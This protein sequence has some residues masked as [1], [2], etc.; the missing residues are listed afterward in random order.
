MSDGRTL[1]VILTANASAYKAALSGAGRDTEEFGRKVDRAGH[2]LDAMGA[3][4]DRSAAQIAGF[5]KNTRDAGNEVDRMSGRLR[6]MLDALTLLGPAMVPIGAVAIPALTGLAAQL[7][8]AG[9]AA[10]STML[11]FIGMGDALTALNA[12]QLNP[13]AA[14]IEKARVALDKLG[15]S[16]AAFTLELDRM[17]PSL[18]T[19][20]QA[21]A[22]GFFPG[23]LD[24]LQSVEHALPTI[25]RLVNELAQSA[26][27]MAASLGD[28]LDSRRF[29]KFSRFVESEARPTM[30]T[31]FDTVSNL[32]NGLGEMWM[33]FDPINDDFGQWLL[34]QSRDFD[35]WAAKLDKTQGFEDFMAYIREEGPRVADALGSIGDMT[36]QIV[37]AA[38]PIGGPVLEGISAMADAVSA[39]A[40]SPIG[41]TLFGAAAA[42]TVLNRGLQMT[43]ALLTKVGIAG[44][45]AGAGAAAGTMRGNIA[46]IKGGLSPSRFTPAAWTASREASAATR[47]LAAAEATARTA[48]AEYVGALKASS[49]QQELIPGAK[50]TQGMTGAVDKLNAANEA[51]VTAANRV[52]EAEERRAAAIRNTARQAAGGAAA[53]AAIG[54]LSTDAGQGLGLTNTAMLGLVGSM[55]GPWG[56]AMGAGVGA[57]I[58]FRSET[59]RAADAWRSFDSV[60][61][62]ASSFT[63]AEG[64]FSRF[65]EQARPTAGGSILSGTLN[66]LTLGAVGQNVPDQINAY[67][68]AADA[69]ESK[70]EDLRLGAHLLGEQFN[71]MGTSTADLDRA[72]QS[73]NPAMSALG[74]STDDLIAAV[75]DGSIIQLV[76]DITEWQQHADSA[77]GQTDAVA[78][79]VKNLGYDALSTADS[80]QQLGTALQNALTPN[81]D[82]EAATDAWHTALTKL[83][84]D[85]K[86][87]KGF[88][89]FGEGAMANRQLTRDYAS[90]SIDRLTKLAGVN[91]TTPEAM[92]KA[93]EATRR[94]FIK[95]GVA[96]GFSAEQMKRRAN[97]LKLTPKLVRTVFHAAGIT[98]VDLRAREL[99]AVYKGMPKDVRTFIQTHGVPQTKAEI[100]DLVKKYHLTEKQRTALVTLK[101]LASK[102]IGDVL[103]RLGI[104]DRTSAHPKVQAEA[105]AAQRALDRAAASLAALDGRVAKSIVEIHT[106]RTGAGGQGRGY[107]G[108]AGGGTVPVTGLG[109]ADRHPY[110]LADGEE[111][112]TDSPSRGRPASTYRPVLKAINRG[113][114]RDVIRGMLAGGGTAGRYGSTL[115][116]GGRPVVVVRDRLPDKLDLVVD[117]QRMTAFVRGHAEQVVHQR[118]IEQDDADTLTERMNWR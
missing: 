102:N 81:I 111:V 118:T 11:A 52:R 13:T 2:D 80:A 67:G 68:D 48:H 60:I 43:A 83:R 28:A 27:D 59:D 25:R 89:G 96:A 113:A 75:Q 31:L 33:A 3:S 66:N 4:S 61:G 99:T 41:T 108:A 65:K 69:A 85:L 44:E 6:I 109:Y 30:A 77:A 26:G 104:L 38:A 55:A 15:P 105:A 12:A 40:D 16:A 47:D 34:D 29:A 97:E 84:T 116:G 19:V 115:A 35:A 112:V 39:I 86:P 90:T 54:V 78:E 5:E 71:I 73:A 100:D 9:G 74:L 107:D 114:S 56:A 62:S 7:A 50:A 49:V 101:D 53:I 17:M 98:Q 21:S 22:S 91:T 95:E 76:Q 57:L 92:A 37:E 1:Y 70:V 87:G 36:L 45:V 24:G 82:L 10:G 42:A 20:Q 58:D 14:N 51:Q 94:E 64:A 106:I 23:A 103:T 72:L 110:L 93:V 32:V 117:G 18:R 46:T 63:E 88:E 79:A 8:I